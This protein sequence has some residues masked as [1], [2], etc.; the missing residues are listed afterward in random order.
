MLARMIAA[1]KK[2]KPLLMVIWSPHVLFTQVD[3]ITLESIDPDRTGEIDWDKDPYPFKTG[4]AEYTV[5]KV[6]RTGLA[7][8]APDV[9]R[10]VH[11]M[12]LTEHE[13]N[14]L[15]LRVDVNEEDMATVASDWISKNQ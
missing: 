7:Q 5:Y 8:S 4:L 11:N 3:L 2:G 15:T 10:L 14:D 1:D 12:V 9:Y 6:I 13:I